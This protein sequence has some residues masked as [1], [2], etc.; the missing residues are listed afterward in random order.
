MS[1]R[2][3]YVLQLIVESIKSK[4]KNAEVILFGSRARGTAK[5]DSDWDLLILLNKDSVSRKDEQVFRHNLIDVELKTGEAISTFVYSKK[6]W[7]NKF[8][9]TPFYENIKKDGIKIDDRF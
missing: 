8:W 6:D 4:D 1:T 7:E 9:V 5:K 2:E 3:E